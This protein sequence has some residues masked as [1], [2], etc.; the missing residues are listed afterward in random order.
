MG[1]TIL[2]VFLILMCLIPGCQ[3]DRE[4]IT[5]SPNITWGQPSNGLRCSIA[6]EKTRWSKGDPVPVSVL[7]ENVSGSTVDLMTIPAFILNEMQYWCPVDIV[8]EDH[9]LPANARSIISLQEGASINS[10]IDISKLGWDR[11]ISSIWPAQ[12]LYSF[13]PPGQYRL[14]LDIEIVN[15]NNPGWIH[16]NEV[17]IT[18]TE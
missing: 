1:H 16:S 9:A 14:R 2:I 3:T 18:M 13:V 8:G 5:Q 6:P 15:G 17:E 4:S 7:A 11:G 12:N 10:I